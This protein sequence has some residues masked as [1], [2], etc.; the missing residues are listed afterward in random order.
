LYKNKTIQAFTVAETSTLLEHYA[1]HGGHSLLT[2]WD[3]L[4]VPSSRVKKSFLYFFFLDFLT[5]E[6]G[7]DKLSRNVGYIPEEISSTLQRKNETTH[8]TIVSIQITA[9]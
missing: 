4:S 8:L 5:L 7:T 6:E 1:A 9:F 2:F 3:N